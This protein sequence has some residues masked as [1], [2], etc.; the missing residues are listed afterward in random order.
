MTQRLG[1]EHLTAG[2]GPSASVPSHTRTVPPAACSGRTKSLPSV[3]KAPAGTQGT[4]SG[5]PHTQRLKNIFLLR[6]DLHNIKLLILK[7]A[8]QWHGASHLVFKQHRQLSPRV[9][10]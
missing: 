5:L 6:R 3:T 4:G 7:C 9:F 10:S 1:P 2:T 8:V